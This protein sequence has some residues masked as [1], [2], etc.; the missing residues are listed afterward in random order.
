MYTINITVYFDDKPKGEI[1]MK[2]KVSKVLASFLVFILLMIPAT[3]IFALESSENTDVK[4]TITH[5]DYKNLSIDEQ[6]KVKLELPHETLTHGKAKLQLFYVKDGGIL[7]PTGLPMYLTPMNIGLAIT[8]V[9]LVVLLVSHKR[10]NTLWTLGIVTIVGLSAMGAVSAQELKIADDINLTIEKGSIFDHNPK[11]IKGYTY[12]GY[13]INQEDEEIKEEKGIVNV[14][15]VDDKNNELLPVFKMKGLVGSPYKINKEIISGYVFSNAFGE[16]SGEFKKVEQTVT[17][18]YTRKQVEKSTVTIKYQDT[19]GNSLR[20]DLVLQGEAGSTIEFTTPQIEGYSFVKREGSMSDVFEDFDAIITLVYD[21]KIEY[22]KVIIKFTEK[23]SGNEA[24][25]MNLDIY[26]DPIEDVSNYYF[27]IKK[28]ITGESVKI[29]T[30][31]PF[32]VLTI[33]SQTPITIDQLPKTIDIDTYY[34]TDNGVEVLSMY[35]DNEK[36]YRGNKNLD[37]VGYSEYKGILNESKVTYDK[38]N[39]TIIVE[40][41]LSSTTHIIDF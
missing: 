4:V 16:L 15:F 28:P 33:T 19:K 23:N 35:E 37:L 39:K 25:T 41:Y 1:I 2:N 21:E 9:G 11:D 22:N 12:K 5:E 20:D 7:P 29:K 30:N 18:V 34:I 8:G 27:K 36:G 3:R 38:E 14:R 31:S 40:Y 32:P 17:L 6:A 26:N 13:I 10:K 24:R